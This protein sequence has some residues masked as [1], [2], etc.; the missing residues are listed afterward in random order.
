MI[1]TDSIP[2]INI[3]HPYMDID[4]RLPG[5]AIGGN[6][7]AHGMIE[8]AVNKG[9]PQMFDTKNNGGVVRINGKATQGKTRLRQ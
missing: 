6:I 3:H 4:L 8:P 2:G 9:N 1:I 5:Y 7:S